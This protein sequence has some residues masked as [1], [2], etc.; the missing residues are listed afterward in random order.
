MMQNNTNDPPH[1]STVRLPTYDMG[2]PCV[3]IANRDALL[4]FMDEDLPRAPA[5]LD[6]RA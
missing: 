2:A 4:D 1:S 5:A 3:D 6:L